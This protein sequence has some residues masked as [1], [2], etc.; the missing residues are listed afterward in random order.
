MELRHWQC[1]LVDLPVY[2]CCAG[3]QTPKTGSKRVDFYLL[4]SWRSIVFLV[5]HV[6]RAVEAQHNGLETRR[7]QLS[8]PHTDGLLPDSDRFW[9]CHS[10]GVY[11]AVSGQNV[12]GEHL[13]KLIRPLF[14]I[15]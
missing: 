15:I 14:H 4:H 13:D 5:K 6:I 11:D 3:G 10:M 1:G 9:T 2:L 7:R 12:I 8:G